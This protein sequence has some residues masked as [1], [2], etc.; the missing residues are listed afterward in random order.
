MI[1]WGVGGVPMVLPNILAKSFTTDL[2]VQVCLKITVIGVV[3]TCGKKRVGFAHRDLRQSDLEVLAFLESESEEKLYAF[4]VDTIP[5]HDA[6]RGRCS[7]SRR[8][9]ANQ[10]FRDSAGT[11]AEMRE[12]G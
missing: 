4:R 7:H 8:F 2:C 3:V 12:G 10:K 11:V 5:S 1:G 6:E 9:V